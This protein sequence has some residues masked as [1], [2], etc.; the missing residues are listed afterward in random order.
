[1][2][3]AEF[4][5]VVSFGFLAQTVGYTPVFAMTGVFW[6]VFSLMSFRELARTD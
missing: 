5:T 4:A 6:A 1:M 2:R 3:L